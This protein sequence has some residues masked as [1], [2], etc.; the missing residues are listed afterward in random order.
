MSIKHKWFKVAAWVLPA[1][2]VTAVVSATV[3]KFGADV[4]GNI[5]S[6]R[7]TVLLQKGEASNCK[8]S[9]AASTLSITG[10]DGNALSSKNPCV[11][12]MPNGAEPLVFTAPV[13]TTFGAA[14]DTDGNVF[15]VTAGVAWADAMAAYLYACD[16]HGAHYF[17]FSRNSIR[18]QTGS[19]AAYMCQE[20]DTDCDGKGDLFAM[21]SGLTIAD[22]VA[23]PCVRVG[24]FEMTMDS[25]NA[26]TVA[27]LVDGRDGF[28]TDQNGSDFLY[29]FGQ[30]GSAVAS[31]QINMGGNHNTTATPIHYS[32]NANT[33]M[34]TASGNIVWAG[35]VGAPA[36]QVQVTMPIAPSTV[37]VAAFPALWTNSTTPLYYYVNSYLYKMTGAALISSELPGQTTQI[38]ASYYAFEPDK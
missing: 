31:Y 5:Y 7:S 35:A 2:F 33:G 22:E 12:G 34:V 25:G 15:G 21:T 4:Y 32:I 17:A 28:G 37:M 6:A 19:A 9:Y 27:T 11:I 10:A 30:N 14:S 36:T 8:L 18:N 16:G 1:L 3:G 38:S 24:S 29:P 20:G 23:H 26:W 13:S